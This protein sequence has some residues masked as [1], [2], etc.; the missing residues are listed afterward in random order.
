RRSRT[1]LRLDVA[2]GAQR[3][4]SVSAQLTDPQGLAVRPG[5]AIV[6][7]DPVGLLEVWPSTGRQRRFSPPLS[8]ASSLQLVFDA[9]GDVV[10]LES[11]GLGVVPFVWGGEAAPTPLLTLPVPGS[12]ATFQGDA[13]AREASGHLLVT[14]FGL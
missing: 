9:A 3:P 12:I 5:G 2:S 7:A 4:L 1:L 8:A 6:V 14:G 10:V 13:L 11:G